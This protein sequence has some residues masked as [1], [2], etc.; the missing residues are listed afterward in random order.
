M[1]TSS[2]WQGWNGGKMKG[3][4]NN[5]HEEGNVYYRHWKTD[6]CHQFTDKLVKV[7][8]AGPPQGCCS[9]GLF[10][11]EA[12]SKRETELQFVSGGHNKDRRC[13]SA[14]SSSF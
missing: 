8:R 10:M 9:T 14:A 5:L 13:C 11:R 12:T 3:K 1:F 7:L 4:K 2:E 6:Q